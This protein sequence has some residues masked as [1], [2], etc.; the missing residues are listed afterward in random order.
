MKENDIRFHVKQQHFRCFAHILNLGV[1]VLWNWWSCDMTHSIEDA[2]NEE[3]E[4]D[5]NDESCLSKL[6]EMFKSI[7]LSE[8][9]N[10]LRNC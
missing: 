5:I 4:G 1:Q 3:I 2:E 7:R 10:K 6:W 8:R 9:Q